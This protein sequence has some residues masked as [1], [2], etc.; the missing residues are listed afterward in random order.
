MKD[1][2]LF[3]AP[4]GDSSIDQTEWIYLG[5]VE[6]CS[7]GWGLEI[8]DSESPAVRDDVRNLLQSPRA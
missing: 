1:D 4:L 8:N 3:W 6:K 5:V 2:Y 7:C